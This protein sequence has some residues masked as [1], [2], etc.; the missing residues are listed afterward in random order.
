MGVLSISW[1]PLKLRGENNMLKKTIKYNDFNGVQRTEDF[2]FN[3]TKA[4]VTEWEMSASGGLG[5]HIHGI[6]AAQN[7]PEI[8]A[9]FKKLIIKSYGVKSPDGRKFIKN[10][11][12]IND[13]IHTE[14]FSE[15]F[16]ELALNDQAAAEFVNGIIPNNVLPSAANS[17]LPGAQ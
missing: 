13:F 1:R 2:Y 3:L 17:S 7:Q 15:L 10:E 9:I 16:M 8:I 5:A 6:V 12:V 11:E 14:A 4:E